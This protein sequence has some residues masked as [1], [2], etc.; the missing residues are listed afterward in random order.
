MDIL[1]LKSPRSISVLA[2]TSLFI[3]LLQ[4]PA[5]AEEGVAGVQ[6]V[7]ISGT[8]SSLTLS[9]EPVPGAVEY[10]AFEELPKPEYDRDALEPIYRGGDPNFTLDGLGAREVSRIRI[11]AVDEDDLVLARTLIRTSTHGAVKCFA[12]ADAPAAASR[13]NHGHTLR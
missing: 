8:E 7:S 1:V 9:W 2:A 13:I 10:V 11:I 4:T 3:P 6:G 12:N 5:I